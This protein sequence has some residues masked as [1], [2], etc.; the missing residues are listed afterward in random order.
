LYT[1]T[2]NL[3]EDER[4]IANKLER[5]SKRENEDEEKSLQAQQIEKDATLPVR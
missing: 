5:E 4:S 1:F 2:N 3:S